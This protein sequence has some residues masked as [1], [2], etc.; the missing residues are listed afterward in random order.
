MLPSLGTSGADE[1]G[2]GGL[3]V[4]QVMPEHPKR[5]N[6]CMWPGWRLS[7]YHLGAAMIRACLALP[8][9]LTMSAF[10]GSPE[11]TR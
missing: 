3:V 6:W 1:R 7:H 2:F 8:P 9:S 4:S 5:K 10:Q 11:E